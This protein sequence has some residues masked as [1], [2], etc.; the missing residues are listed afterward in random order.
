MKITICVGSSCHLKGSHKV[1][2]ILSDL[3]IQ[4]KLEHKITLAG[5]FCM[6]NCQ[7]HVCVSVDNDV[8]SVSPE[9]TEDFF[10]NTIIP[11]L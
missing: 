7:E 9:T 5:T 11:K 3:I 8:Y 10:K 6:N 1:A 4:N 2:E